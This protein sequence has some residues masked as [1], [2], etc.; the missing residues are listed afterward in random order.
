[1]STRG[2]RKGLNR[3]PVVIRINNDDLKI[4]P[5]IYFAA[6]GSYMINDIV[7]VKN[8][9]VTIGYTFDNLKWLS[10]KE[11]L[12]MKENNFSLPPN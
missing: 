2:L 10:L 4:K 9:Y 6:P 7:D 11:R 3:M 1:M 8:S 5:D 12:S